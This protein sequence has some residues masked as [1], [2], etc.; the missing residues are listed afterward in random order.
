[1]V[2]LFHISP[3]DPSCLPSPP[4]PEYQVV[5]APT[6]CA[7]CNS[8]PWRLAQSAIYLQA[9]LSHFLIRRGGGGNKT[10]VLSA[11]LA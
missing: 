7:K 10:N 6:G 1:M 5:P 9:A 3:F 2:Y 11:G 8:E 4:L